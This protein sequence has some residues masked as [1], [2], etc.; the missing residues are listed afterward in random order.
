MLLALLSFHIHLLEDVLG[1]RGPEGYQWPILYLAPFYSSLQLVWRGQ[2]G[3]NAWPNILLAIL[4]ADHA[5]VGM[6]RRILAA[7]NGVG[8]GRQCRG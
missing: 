5:V 8:Q 1:S 2:R 7:G 6:A 3:L 4:L